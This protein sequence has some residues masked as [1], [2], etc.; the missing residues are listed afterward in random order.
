[1]TP[2]TDVKTS[3]RSR[4]E[5]QAGSSHTTV[6]TRCDKIQRV[7]RKLAPTTEETVKELTLLNRRSGR[8]QRVL[9][10]G[11]RAPPQRVNQ[12]TG[13]V[14][15]TKECCGWACEPH[16]EG[17]TSSQE[18]WSRSKSVA[19]GLASP[20]PRGALVYV[21]RRGYTHWGQ[22]GQNRAKVPLK[23]ILVW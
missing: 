15:A 12:F 17:C 14:V 3:I 21:I 4:S 10:P 2:P 11:L 1:M 18:K 13:E 5:Q 23:S 8:N 19:T 7:G 16:P 9:R 6:V 22:V 20:T